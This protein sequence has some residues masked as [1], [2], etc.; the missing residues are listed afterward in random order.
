MLA[1]FFLLLF[2]T[3]TVSSEENCS[4][5][6]VLNYLN[7]TKN[8]DNFFMTR[9]V[10]D[11]R[12]ATKLTLDVLLYAILDMKEKEQ[13][14]VPYVWIVK[15]WQNNYIQWNPDDFCDIRFVNVPTEVM[16]KP[17]LTIEEMIE[18]DK[19]PPAPYLVIE[20]NGYVT[21]INDQVLVSTCRMHIY[22]FPFDVQ[23]CNLTFK[24]VIHSDEEISLSHNADSSVVTRVSREMMRT[25]SEW[26]FISMVVTDKM[27]N[28]FG[29]NQS[30]I[31]YTITMK[32]QS[33][34]YIINFILPI[35]FF[36][37]LDLS[38]FL[39][40]EHGGEKLSFKVTV[41]LAVTVMQL[42]L[43]EIL[44]STSNR[45]PLIA[46]YCIGIFALM[47]LSL[48]ETIVL[49]Y[50]IEK[51][52]K[53]E[54]KKENLNE[55]FE[56]KQV[57]TNLHILGEVNKLFL[58][59]CG[60]DSSPDKTPRELLP[61]AKESALTETRSRRP[62]S[63]FHAHFV[64]IV[65]SHL[66]SASARPLHVYTGLCQDLLNPRMSKN[67]KVLNLR[68]KINGN[69]VDLSLCNLTEV[70]VKELALFPKATVVDLSCNNI[71][72]LPPEFCSLT[73]LVKV[74]LSKNQLTCLPD[75]LGNLVNLQHLDLYNNKLTVL[76]VSFSQLR[77]LKWLDLKD[78]PLEPGLAKAAG[79][80]LDE[81]QC[82]Q[83]ATKVLQHMRA[84]Q[85]EVDRAR[86]K[87]LL[88]EK[89]LERKRE[90]KQ[91]E[92]EAREKEARKREKAEE[93]E[94]RRKE[95]N[96]QKAALAAQEQQKK[97]EEKK[98]K[99]GQAADKK[100]IVK[101]APKPQQSFVGLMFKLLLLLLLGFAGVVA[102]CRLTDL[103]K[104]AM[105]VPVNVAVDDSLSWAREQE[106]VVRQLVLKLSSAFKE[107]L[108]SA[109]TSK[110]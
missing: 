76:P 73:H 17:D 69:E 78:N 5:Q 100:V 27:I 103:Q 74:D 33:A 71:T 54:K 9:P 45:I 66:S 40:S 58:C 2:I 51:D 94:K 64:R 90:A 29:F 87:R 82:K 26:V 52:N 60:P 104:E 65:K 31:I 43:N 42:V 97:K 93:K 11:H 30:T 48:L 46:V 99:N 83:C 12:N 50:L 70:P 68:D 8:N 34:L 110:N 38:S 101:S 102:A 6:D 72:S 98:K 108:E 75:D 21:T 67:S 14:F 79:D 37:C 16:W 57:K 15:S 25:Q 39:I 80:C 18:K 85:D 86:E 105:C 55:D 28:I 88:R 81:K 44:P 3:D 53:T 1:G 24:S 13:V 22:K 19:A 95:Y 23:V 96:A 10:N 35:L 106:V 20:F 4:Y 109:Q 63:A 89:E 36:L 56:N 77:S 41:L 59:E 84:I 91:R 7:L 62:V 92:R 107:F 47:L 61:V 49:M 32:R